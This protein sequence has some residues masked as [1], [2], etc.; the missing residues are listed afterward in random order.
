MIYAQE[1]YPA[2]EVV[3]S[4]GVPDAFLFKYALNKINE[5]AKD[6][7]PFFSV[8]LLSAY[9]NKKASG[10]PKLFTTSSAG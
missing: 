3:N 10:T 5:K 1:D 7:Q 9:L 8:I 6:K 4:F 2:E